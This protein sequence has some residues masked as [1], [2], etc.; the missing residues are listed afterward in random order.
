MVEGKA[1]DYY[2]NIVYP[3]VEIM[4]VVPNHQKNRDYYKNPSLT[5]SRINFDYKENKTFSCQTKV[6][7]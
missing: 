4:I 1:S 6:L 5:H 7:I 2:E 3:K